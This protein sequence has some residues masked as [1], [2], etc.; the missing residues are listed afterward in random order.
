M[1]QLCSLMPPHDRYFEPYL[2]GGAVAAGKIA[3][4]ASIVSDLDKD[5]I[6][7]HQR[8]PMPSTIYM[9]VDALILIDRYAP[10]MTV[11]DLV[12]L[13]P[14]YLP[15]TR[16]KLKLYKHE[17]DEKHHQQILSLI[18]T[19][20]ARVMLSGYRSDMYDDAL[21][22]WHR[23]DF[24]AMTRGGPRTES[25]WCNFKPFEE[26]HDTRFIGGNYRERERIKRKKSRWVS[27]FQAMPPGERAAIAE[28]LKIA[29]SGACRRAS[30]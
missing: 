26:F 30:S 6:R 28:A 22:D 3:A 12:Y 8:Y 20:P 5:V 24:Q 19:L 7:Y 11:R 2:G 13:D 15:E 18:Q 1:Q 27:R 17:P 29:E 4:A 23:H 21:K 10:E 14:P 9:A 16:S 25:V